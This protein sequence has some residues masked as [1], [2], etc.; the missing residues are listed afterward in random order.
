MKFGHEKNSRLKHLAE[1]L[2]LLPK[3]QLYYILHELDKDITFDREV[4]EFLASQFINL[5]NIISELPDQALS[6]LLS[7][8]DITVLS[9]L[10][11]TL[12]DNEKLQVQE[13][14]GKIRYEDM[15]QEASANVPGN[16]DSPDYEQATAKL[17]ETLKNEISN[18]Q[19]FYDGIATLLSVPDCRQYEEVT[20]KTPITFL[21]LSP[22]AGPGEGI[23]ILI[24]APA[25]AG[26]TIS[27]SMQD[28]KARYWK[29]EKWSFQI[30]L[31]AKGF[32]FQKVFPQTGTG[33]KNIVAYFPGYGEV[34][35]S[36]WYAASTHSTIAIDFLDIIE[37][38]HEYTIA[39][40]VKYLQTLNAPL[41]AEVFCSH[42]GIRID[43]QRLQL[44]DGRGKLKLRRD[45]V[46]RHK[47]DLFVHWNVN[48][49]SQVMSRLSIPALN[50]AGLKEVQSFESK[51]AD[52]R[53]KIIIQVPLDRAEPWFAH[54][55]TSYSLDHKLRQNIIG[56]KSDLY[57]K[58]LAKLS[59]QTMIEKR[60]LEDNFYI[61]QEKN[62]PYK[63][64]SGIYHDQIEYEPEEMEILSDLYFTFYTF[65]N[66][67][68]RPVYHYH[69]IRKNRPLI[70]PFL[71]NFLNTGEHVSTSVGYFL[72]EETELVVTNGAVQ[73]KTLQGTGFFPLKLT[74]G[75][76]VL[77]EAASIGHKE[78]INVPQR[79][80][81]A[82]QWRYIPPGTI[83]SPPGKNNSLTLY[84]SATS[85]AT[86]FLEKTLIDYPWGCSEQTSAKLT[87]LAFLLAAEK[88]DTASTVLIKSIEGGTRVLLGYRSESGHYSLFN[89][90]TAE[91]SSLVFS[92]LLSLESLR[93]KLQNKVPR[94]YK[95]FDELHIL[96]NS[97]GLLK[98]V[99]T[100]ESRQNLPPHMLEVNRILEQSANRL[101][102]NSGRL[103]LYNK[104]Y[105]SLYSLCSRLAALLL[106]ENSDSIEIFDEEKTTSQ[107]VKTTGIKKILE[108]LNLK[109]AVYNKI[110]T[111]KTK[112]LTPALEKLLE[113][114]GP[115]HWTNSHMATM[116]SVGFMNLLQDI[117]QTT[118]AWLYSRNG[119]PVSIQEPEV[120]TENVEI[121]SPNT[122]IRV[123]T[124]IE[125]NK[126]IKD[127]TVSASRLQLRPGQTM[128]LTFKPKR[129]RPRIIHLLLPPI[130]IPASETVKIQ[131]QTYSF[132]CS[133]QEI[134]IP[135]I[136]IKPGKGNLEFLLEDMSNPSDIGK[137]KI[138]T[139]QVVP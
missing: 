13:A 131:Q 76:S 79:E 33:H 132:E 23:S 135:L 44:E 64:I 41:S 1:T 39:F 61:F 37:D 102:L 92:N 77:I 60:S 95:L 59:V 45:P 6:L 48:E 42:C 36:I 127:I 16:L 38:Q 129:T 29:G 72:P 128:E 25:M 114:S 118:P 7:N 43:A 115:S 100:P 133:H 94:L 123:I 32:F 35:R 51:N 30:K 67:T 22:F 2:K 103:T 56:A 46:D 126:G 119:I 110:T 17:F 52:H 93:N 78:E 116:E 117:S 89:G 3:N 74:A 122:F 97:L 106:K 86:L 11:F 84:P 34:Y 121:K 4:L 96:L 130:I 68:L 19:I 134:I 98:D 139:I 40:A 108:N 8:L 65:R 14:I 90:P 125:L 80:L 21:T 50:K 5:K 15:Q 53:K 18:G 112:I 120:L 63:F 101:Q 26:A 105:E 10:L 66:D 55:S 62:E 27:I 49:K 20:R 12:N 99:K 69:S 57:G 70:V 107:K 9:K 31:D 81:K 54:V 136:A 83:L 104:E 91:A 73:N 111:N 71:P 75:E 113:V 87:G 138:G 124:D 88:H 24:Y 109:K 58:C 28:Q 82:A 85:L 47:H 137:D